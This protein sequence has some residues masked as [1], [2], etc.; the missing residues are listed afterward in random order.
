[1]TEKVGGSYPPTRPL[2]RLASDE[3]SPPRA[4]HERF[5]P[6]VRGAGVLVPAAVAGVYPVA[7]PRAAGD[8]AGGDDVS[9]PAVE[10][11]PWAWCCHWRDCLGIG[12]PGVVVD[13]VE[14]CLSCHAAGG[15]TGGEPAGAG[16][17]G[18]GRAG[19]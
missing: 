5:L 10:H 12:V 8:G 3:G 9:E 13:A 11:R 14:L 15:P 7:V 18:T 17:Q 1:M 6:A 2:W 4:R 19:E 16:R